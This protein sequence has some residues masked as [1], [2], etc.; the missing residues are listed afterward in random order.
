MVSETGLNNNIQ[1]CSFYLKEKNKELDKMNKLFVRINKLYNT[2]NTD[3][4]INKTDEIKQEGKNLNN[5]NE[6]YTTVFRSILHD[7]QV[8]MRSYAEKFE[9]LGDL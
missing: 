2:N 5:N 9:T 7:Y 3:S 4:L 1:K 6:K 8:T